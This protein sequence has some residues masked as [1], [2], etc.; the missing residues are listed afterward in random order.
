MLT[1]L[2]PAVYGSKEGRSLSK[3]KLQQMHDRFYA[4]YNVLNNFPDL[5]NKQK[6]GLCKR[7]VS[8][9][10]KAKK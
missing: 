1:L 8:S 10:W 3:N 7:A 4:Y 2:E 9:I 6:I 5:T